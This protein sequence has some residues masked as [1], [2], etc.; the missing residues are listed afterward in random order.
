[1]VVQSIF[2][3]IYMSIMIEF[4]FFCMDD[5]KQKESVLTRK[6]ILWFSGCSGEDGFVPDIVS[7]NSLMKAAGIS[8]L[9]SWRGE[10]F[11]ELTPTNH[12][13]WT[14]LRIPLESTEL[15]NSD[16]MKHVKK[17][18]TLNLGVCS[19]CSY[20]GPFFQ[21]Y[22]GGSSPSIHWEGFIYPRSHLK[23]ELFFF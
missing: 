7:Y 3:G 19:Y 9:I 2:I 11:D 12:P 13:R 14:A 18:V 17:C 22:D 23:V 15:F 16:M 21:S 20:L 8:G 10:L 1:M 4:P 5:H 6:K